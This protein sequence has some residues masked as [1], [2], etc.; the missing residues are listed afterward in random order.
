MSAERSTVLFQRLALL[1]VLGFLLSALP[2]AERLWLSPVSPGWLPPSPLRHL[3]HALSGAV[4]EPIVVLALVALCALVVWQLLCP[5]RGWAWA[6]IWLL[7]LNLMN[8]AW[9]AGSGGQQLMAN[10]L[11]WCIFLAVRS[12]HARFLG[13]WAIRLQLLL[14][15]LATGLHKLTG[16]HWIDGTAMGIVAT[17]GAFGPAWVAD[18]PQLARIVTWSVL[19]FQ[20]TFP[21]AVWSRRL[22]LPWMAFGAA[23]HLATA[24][25]MDIPEMGLA[26]VVCY[27][28]W[29]D[30]GL[31]E[32]L[33]PLQRLSGAPLLP[34]R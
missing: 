11:F 19:L 29:L 9:L 31:L 24:L 28:S 10:V 27:A 26:F 21:L 4:P 13:W 6:L 15:Y 17:D 8:R 23:F 14:A 32:R 25:W 20:L 18:A 16:A 12:G 3:T 34:F 33:P 2:S 5:A 7:Y 30:D 22:R 1:W